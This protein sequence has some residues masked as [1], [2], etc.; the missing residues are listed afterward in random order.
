MT[1]DKALFQRF[2]NDGLPAY[3][4]SSIQRK[5]RRKFIRNIRNQ[6]ILLTQVTACLC[7]GNE[8]ICIA[9]KD[10][11]GL[12]FFSILCKNCGLLLLNP[13]I[14]ESSLKEYYDSIY[15]ILVLGHQPGVVMENLVSERQGENIFDFIKSHLKQKS[16]LVLEIGCASGSN[17][18]VFKDLAKKQGIDCELYGSEYEGH[19][20]EWAR[21]RGINV[22]KGGVES[23]FKF[24]KTF[25]IIILSHVFEHFFDPLKE[26]TRIKSLLKD[27]GLLYIEVPGLLN[28]SEYQNDL[29]GYLVHSHNFNFNLNSL[30]N[31]LSING[32]SLLKG[33]EDVQALFLK[34]QEAGVIN[35]NNP[36]LILNHLK[37]TE[38]NKYIKPKGIKLLKQI[39]LKIFYLIDNI[40]IGLKP[41]FHE[42]IR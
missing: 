32:F 37:D 8:F 13:K 35:R 27:D 4:L 12:P 14:S 25:D 41:D 24:G 7:G 1:D 31:I 10:R 40:F 17:L 23:L 33:N 2:D 22:V 5:Y 19:Y 21:K 11:F 16:L 26:L 6:K 3:W 18:V 30:E 34:N 9:K 15:H 29:I 20:V 36:E 42:V 39:I 28:L 38:L